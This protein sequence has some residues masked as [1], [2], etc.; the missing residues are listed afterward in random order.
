[1]SVV[2]AYTSRRCYQIMTSLCLVLAA[3][4]FGGSEAQCP[5]YFPYGVGTVWQVQS[6]SELDYSLSQ[7]GTTDVIQLNVINGTKWVNLGGQIETFEA[8]IGKPP[9]TS[10]DLSLA[11]A[12]IKINQTSAKGLINFD[13]SGHSPGYEDLLSSFGQHFPLW[14][15][16]NVEDGPPEEAMYNVSPTGT[17][18]PTVHLALEWSEKKYGL[19]NVFAR[20][21][22]D[23]ILLKWDYDKIKNILDQAFAK[24]SV[25]DNDRR[26]LRTKYKTIKRQHQGS[27]TELYINSLLH[28]VDHID[29]MDEEHM[30]FLPDLQITETS[31]NKKDLDL[32]ESYI[33]QAGMAESHCTLLRI[34]AG[35]FLQPDCLSSL[36]SYLNFR[37]N[38]KLIIHAL[39]HDFLPVKEFVT[40]LNAVGKESVLLDLPQVALE[41]IRTLSGFPAIQKVSK[42]SSSSLQDQPI[43][44]K[45]NDAFSANQL[46]CGSSY[47]YNYYYVRVIIVAL[48][49]VFF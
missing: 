32:V 22:K 36:V 27:F 21:E 46:R 25:P 34:R 17:I 6:G 41:K 20:V 44:A 12:L 16:Q 35:I 8:V 47:F 5:T 29:D 38:V 48:L 39:P 7:V 37:A 42:K 18:S 15:L 11:Q 10:S 23:N 49:L 1:M 31:C 26:Y 2:P 13:S 45:E 30:K 28:L 19:D 40:A 43:R 9:E 14:Q 3:L 33:E 4:A 24:H